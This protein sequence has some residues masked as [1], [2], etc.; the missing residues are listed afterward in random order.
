MAGVKGPRA[1]PPA[2][3]VEII[4][5]DRQTDDTVGGSVIVPDEIR[6]NGQPLLVEE[7]GIK[8]H[9][10]DLGGR[11]DLARVTVTL[12]ARRVVIAAEHD[13]KLAGGA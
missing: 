10:M 12:L 11:G 13:L 9:E 8:V 6:I 4:E 2:A 7:G 5:R 3:V 1:L